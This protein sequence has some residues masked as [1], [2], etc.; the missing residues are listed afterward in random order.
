MKGQSKMSR[1]NR[2]AGTVEYIL[3]LS[4][5]VISLGMLRQF[6]EAFAVYVKNYYEDYL[7]CLLDTGELPSLGYE[8]AQGDCDAEFKPF[9]LADGRPPNDIPPATATSGNPPTTTAKQD[10]LEEQNPPKSSDNSDEG[11]NSPGATEGAG[12]APGTGGGPTLLGSDDSG[13]TRNVPL[14]AEDGGATRSNGGVVQYDSSGPQQAGGAGGEG[15]PQFVPAGTVAS[16]GQTGGRKANVPAPDVGLE[17]KARRVPA[18][19]NQK[20]KED[21]K[22]KGLTFP[23]FIKFLLIAVLLILMLVFFGGQALSISKG[24][25]K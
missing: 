17:D 2:G 7:T 20:K 4:V 15:R 11:G 5:V 23:D 9:S 6:N 3:M 8:G 10:P 1:R 14:S 19:V 24:S 13:R 18:D 21:D 12:N 22:D 16:D 25:E